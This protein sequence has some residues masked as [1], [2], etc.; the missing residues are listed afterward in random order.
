MW[1]PAQHAAVLGQSQGVLDSW[2]GAYQLQNAVLC[3]TQNR[4]PD[5]SSFKL[6]HQV[7]SHLNEEVL[8]DGPTFKVD[9]QAL[10]IQQEEGTGSIHVRPDKDLVVCLVCLFHVYTQPCVLF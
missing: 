4:A 8:A 6:L 2:F 10:N 3:F 5:S 7:S 1:L 9:G